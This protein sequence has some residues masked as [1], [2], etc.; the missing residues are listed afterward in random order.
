MQ[1]CVCVVDLGASLGSC[2]SVKLVIIGGIVLP[3]AGMPAVGSAIGP[4]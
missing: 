1:F 2:V 3:L 4:N